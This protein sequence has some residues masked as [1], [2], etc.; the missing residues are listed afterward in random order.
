MKLK[1]KDLIIS[2]LF[3]ILMLVIIN[4]FILLSVVPDYA[5]LYSNLGTK[6]PALTAFYISLGHFVFRW[7]VPASLFLFID[8]AIVAAL[9]FIIKNKT[10]LI[11]IYI[12]TAGA[13]LVFALL[14][15][16]S[17]RLPLMR[18]N[19]ALPPI[20]TASETGGLSK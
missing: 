4:L 16:Y 7:L 1:E 19:K 2:S 13:L 10:S 5:R 17:I 11:A 20:G 15:V 6:L 3:A 9:A 14:S 8:F 12:L 18:I